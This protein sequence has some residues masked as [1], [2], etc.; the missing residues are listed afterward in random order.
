MYTSKQFQ[1]VKF[2]QLLNTV[3]KYFENVLLLFIHEQKC[4][5]PPVYIKRPLA[6]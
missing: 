5:L 4:Y 2:M 6:F 1:N 3:N